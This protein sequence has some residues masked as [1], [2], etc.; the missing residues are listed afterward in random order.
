[1][2]EQNKTPSKN[3][4]QWIESVKWKLEN[5]RK[6]YTQQTS[7]RNE[8]TKWKKL[9]KTNNC[10]KCKWQTCVWIIALECWK[11]Y[12]SWINATPY[13]CT[14]FTFAW[15]AYL[16]IRSRI[17]SRVGHCVFAKTFRKVCKLVV[18]ACERAGERMCGYLFLCQWILFKFF[19]TSET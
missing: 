9:S 11:G 16:L 3:Q 6:M 1:M 5:N 13:K 15:A 12:D 4:W 14:F 8:A 7:P 19:A 2:H 10:S 18:R 17:C